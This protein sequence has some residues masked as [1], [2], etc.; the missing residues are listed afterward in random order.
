MLRTETH[1][2]TQAHKTDKQIILIHSE[3]THTQEETKIQI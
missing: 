3:H 1:T 2:K